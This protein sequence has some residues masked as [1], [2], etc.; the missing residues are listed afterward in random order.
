MAS[1]LDQLRAMTVV[2]AITYLLLRRRSRLRLPDETAF[3]FA[4][5]AR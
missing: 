5:A 1:K 3:T 4:E 2:V